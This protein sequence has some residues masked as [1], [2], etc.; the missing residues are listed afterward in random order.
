MQIFTEAS[1]IRDFIRQAKKSGQSVGF[2]P[3]MGALHDGHLSLIQKAG[4]ENDLVISSIFINPTQFNNPLDFE[5]YPV[6]IDQDIA[7]LE[8]QG[9]HLLFLPTVDEIYP[10]DFEKR[11]YPLGE[12]ENIL[13]GPTRPSHFQGVCMVVERL[14]ELIPCHRL[15]L[16]EKD[17]QQCLV[18]Q[19]L[20]NLNAMQIEMV[21]CPTIRE[22]DGL[23]M[24]SRN[25]RLS[26]S[27]RKQASQIHKTLLWLHQNI[28][29]FPPNS[30]IDQAT[31][32]LESAGF[33]VDY[34]ALTNN[35][36]IPIKQAEPGI[37]IRALIAVH[38]N[39]IRLIDNMLLQEQTTTFEN[40]P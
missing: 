29:T 7:N 24:S 2:V 40:L 37:A 31:R 25:L 19:T 17:Y 35:Q 30:L 5:K 33:R 6:T 14:L 10:V 20:L 12:L 36:L 8:K 16:G 9:C 26:E 13:E 39:E 11:T 34:V 4:S 22:S 3:T 32:H 1:K 27:E 38:L 18:I 23:A 21:I 15:Y 28:S